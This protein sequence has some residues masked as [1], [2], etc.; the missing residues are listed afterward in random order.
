MGNTSRTSASYLPS[1]VAQVSIPFDPP[2]SLYVKST[3]SPSKAD[4]R[5][6]RRSSIQDGSIS[7][8]TPSVTSTTNSR[9]TR[10]NAQLPQRVENNAEGGRSATPLGSQERRSSPPMLDTLHSSLGDNHM[11]MEACP[12]SAPVHVGRSA[13]VSMS[14]LENEA[15][16]A[17]RMTLTVTTL[18]GASENSNKVEQ[19]EVPSTAALATPSR[20][21]SKRELLRFRKAKAAPAGDVAA[22]PAKRFSLPF[23]RNVFCCQE[24]STRE[25][26]LSQSQPNAEGGSPSQIGVAKEQVE[27]GIASKKSN[28]SRTLSSFAPLTSSRLRRKEEEDKERSSSGEGSIKEASAIAPFASHSSPVGGTVTLLEVEEDEEEE[29]KLQVEHKHT[30]EEEGKEGTHEATASH[31]TALHAPTPLRSTPDKEGQEEKSRSEVEKRMNAVDDHHK[32]V[33]DKEAQRPLSHA[34]LEPARSPFPEGLSSDPFLP[35]HQRK[36]SARPKGMPNTPFPGETAS[37]LRPT[38]RMSRATMMGSTSQAPT[39]SIP[40]R[41]LRRVSSIAGSTASP[42]PPSRSFLQRVLHFLSCSEDTVVQ[43][44][45]A[46]SS[47]RSAAPSSVCPTPLH[48]L[49]TQDVVE[50]THPPQ[51]EDRNSPPAIS[52]MAASVSSSSSGVFR[53]MR[54]VPAPTTLDADRPSTFVASLISKADEEEDEDGRERGTHV[55]SS[56]ENE[57][58]EN[59]SLVK[60]MCSPSPWRKSSVVT[61]TENLTPFSSRPSFAGDSKRRHSSHANAA[62]LSSQVVQI[63]GWVL[64]PWGR[65]G[66]AVILRRASRS[67]EEIPIGLAFPPPTLLEDDKNED[68]LVDEEGSDASHSRRSRT[69]K[70]PHRSRGTSE[71]RG[72]L[73]LASSSSSSSLSSSSEKRKSCCT[74]HPVGEA[75]QSLHLTPRPSE[76]DKA[77]RYAW[78]PHPCGTSVPGV[79]AP[80][81]L[82]RR[83]SVNLPVSSTTSVDSGR[84]ANARRRGPSSCPLERRSSVSPLKVKLV[85]SDG[86]SL[87]F[88]SEGVQ[89]KPQQD[90][91]AVA[92]SAGE[93]SPSAPSFSTSPLPAAAATTSTLT[94]PKSPSQFEE[95]TSGTASPLKESNA[96]GLLVPNDTEGGPS[97]SPRAAAPEGISRGGLL[98]PRNASSRSSHRTPSSECL[99]P[100]EVLSLDALEENERRRREQARSG[101]TSG[102]STV[103]LL[104]P[105]STGTTTTTL[106]SS[107][108]SKKAP[109]PLQAQHLT[110]AM[111]PSTADAK[112]CPDTD[113]EGGTPALEKRLATFTP[114]SSR[115]AS[116]FCTS[117]SRRGYG[118]MEKRELPRAAAVH[119]GN[120]LSVVYVLSDTADL[121]KKERS[122]R[123]MTH[124][125]QEAQC[126]KERRTSI[127][128][129]TSKANS[130]PSRCPSQLSH[131]CMQ[132]FVRSVHVVDDLPHSP[133][134]HENEE[135]ETKTIENV[136]GSAE[137]IERHAEDIFS[138]AS[139]G[140]KV[141]VEHDTCVASNEQDPLAMQPP[142]VV[143]PSSHHRVEPTGLTQENSFAPSAKHS[144]AV[145]EGGAEASIVESNMNSR[146]SFTPLLVGAFREPYVDSLSTTLTYV[147]QT[148]EKLPLS[149]IRSHSSRKST[150]CTHYTDMEEPAPLSSS[151]ASSRS[152]SVLMGT[153]KKYQCTSRGM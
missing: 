37:S 90:D 86:S 143:I 102:C 137:G 141:E 27:G 130:P 44:P 136:A 51:V 22:T 49:S 83:A 149:S 142:D 26:A 16:C 119:A 124:Q 123:G 31:E 64:E 139:T 29:E 59:G 45:P 116:S 30:K 18:L 58:R 144:D 33:E 73:S 5:S 96:T 43:A 25:R 8:T 89:G 13:A 38:P 9:G 85:K 10:K 94:P 4:F 56:V 125:E 48:R 12:L 35:D 63:R 68:V 79:H 34:P 3:L 52:S 101:D 152:A 24:S 113:A 148:I 60:R 77:W 39:R 127:L 134:P 23:G 6:L 121:E 150:P 103:P 145:E 133:D 32:Q 50:G 126:K 120:F 74:F 91:M 42:T 107:L 19:K 147:K 41:N 111:G 132:P 70:E 153:K 97:C 128:Q 87:S 81:A 76:P 99:P 95:P 53:G 62:L 55:A 47:L 112:R 75:M 11:A 108:L 88:T 21:S 106:A 40:G 82:H 115:T 67:V 80:A 20:R 14:S 28:E 151:S 140:V 110:T 71:T 84:K 104:S 118:W 36:T 65:E 1:S 146:A 15:S 57:G 114:K 100:V 78:K 117:P 46:A 69:R 93:L 105:A 109:A 129:P 2:M 72:T 131:P 138:R 7:S 135:Q 98:S 92:A 54:K 66:E 122:Q 17:K 61:S